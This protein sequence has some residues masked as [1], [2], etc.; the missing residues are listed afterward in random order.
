MSNNRRRNLTRSIN[1][2]LVAT[3]SLGASSAALAQQS[4]PAVPAPAERS[5]L[6]PVT[7]TAERRSENIKDV[8]ISISTV[9]GEKL[10]VL[11]SSGEDVR[12]LSGRVPRLN[13]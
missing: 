1:G 10:D 9:S 11:N 3:V 13:I 4:A 2:C 5:V 6:D 7:V 8:P 12:F